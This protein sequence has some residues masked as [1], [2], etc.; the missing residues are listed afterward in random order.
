LPLGAHLRGGGINFAIFSRHATAVSLLLFDDGQWHKSPSE[1]ALDPRVNR[2]GDI[3]HLWVAGIGPGTRYAWRVDGP[4]APE[5]GDRFNRNRLLLDPYAPALVGTEHWDFARVCNESESPVD[6]GDAAVK[7]RCLVPDDRFDWEDDQPPRIPW[8]DT[9]IYECHVRGFTI[10]P[11]SAVQHPGTFQGV[12]EK[13]P[14]LRQLGVTAIE[15]LPVQEFHE[16]ELTV[17]NPLTG[18]RLRN[19]WG[20]STVAFFAPRENY[21]SRRRP[22]VQVSEFKTM[23][24]ALHRA[25]VEVILDIVFNHTAEGDQNG[26]TLNFRGLDNR[27]YYL[28]EKD[29]RYYRNYSGTGNT[30]NCNHPVVRDYIL[31][32]LRHW[33]IEMHVD[34][35][36]FDLASVM[37]RDEDGKL[38]A[39]APLLERIA[40]DP[41]LRDVKLVAEAWD[42]AGV[43]QVGHFPGQRWSE[44]NGR[45]RDDVRR[46][47]RGDPG[48]AGALASR[49]CGSAD[50]YQR[51]GKQPLNSIN[52]LTCHDGFTLNDLVSY[53]HKHNEANGEDNRDGADENCSDNCGVEGPSDDPVIESLRKRQIRNMLATL[54]LSR[55][56]PMLLGGDEFRR[57]Q[58]GNNNAYCQDNETSWYDWSLLHRH[59]DIHDFTRA[60]IALRR[61]HPLLR[62]EEFYTPD[63]VTWFNA[64]GR[65]PDWS[66]PDRHLG[67]HFHP[68]RPVP[69]ELC[70]LCNA[71][72]HPLDMQLPEQ[73][74]GGWRRV[75]DT[76]GV[77]TTEDNAVLDNNTVSLLP[78]SLVVLERVF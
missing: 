61:R 78:F 45:Y 29:P 64:S 37:E 28:L 69:D 73:G 5:Q 39:N 24:R 46:F 14:Y 59:G 8:S 72:D 12:V 54:M 77:L 4:Y 71:E 36:R 33:V 57:S 32:C 7:A 19:Y 25:G 22:G 26:P 13:I 41:I 65:T 48:L 16:N 56:V 23:V 9:V 63:E 27:I 31:D 60:M 15:L 34:G 44:W 51:S 52:Y 1:V 55:G 53:R 68:L 3:W 6:A 38:L 2:T 18:E 42:A 10:H 43:Y 35:F 66:A 58:S 76:V 75:V 50:L 74:A 70:I 40:E 67:C 17:R 21:S 30:F 11:S 20:Y 47:W 62:Q 49:L